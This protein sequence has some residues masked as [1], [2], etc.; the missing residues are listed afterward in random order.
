MQYDLIVIGSGPG[1]YRAA[2]LAAQRGLKVGI[3]EKA[4]WGGCGL[5]R[6]CVPKNDWHHSAKLIAASRSYAKRGVQGA[7]SGDLAQAW[8]HQKKVVKSVRDSYISTMKKFGIAGFAAQAAFVDN[9]TIALDGHDRLSAQHFIVATGASAF[10]PKPFSLTD[11][12]V[13]TSDEL[14]S[15]PPPVGKRVAIVGS[16][17]VGAEFAFILAMLGKEVVWISQNSPLSASCFS[18]AALQLLTEKFKHHGIEPKLGFR[19][20][21]VEILPEGVKL[22]L[23]GGAEEV[24]VDWVLLGTGRRPH[25][26][27]LNLDAAGVSTDSK[28][29]VKVNEYLQTT[30]PHV[31]AI[32]DVANQRMSANQALADAQI[33]VANIVQAESRKQDRKA[34]P[35]LVYSALELGRIGLNGAAENKDPVIGV[36]SFDTNP[37]AVGQDAA[38]GFIRLVADAQS[39]V[40][41]SGEVVGNEAGELIHLIAQH[42]GQPDALQHLAQACYSHPDRAE[43]LFNAAEAIAAKLSAGIPQQVISNS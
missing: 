33:A 31:F 22:I 41:L 1:G 19:P 23:Q 11:G 27:G 17:T 14:F 20:E 3:V 18:P 36:A 42:Y 15:Q 43:E 30:Q 4:E 39:G 25:T 28:G 29:Y 12:R 32:G 38:E 10:V 16:G 13:L 5:N 35:D 6:G 37:R 24:I 40:L 8:E 21:A 26:T 7:L 2:V 9:H 34:V